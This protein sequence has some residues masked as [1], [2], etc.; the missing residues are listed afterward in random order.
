MNLYFIPLTTLFSLAIMLVYTKLAGYRQI[1]QLT[2]YDYINT[3]TLGNLAAQ[4]ATSPDEDF[5][6]ALIAIVLYGAFAILSS[7]LAR[8][9]RTFRSF[10]SGQPIVLMEKGRLYRDSFTK[11]RINLDDFEA[12][13]RAQGYFDL[14]QVG[15]AV[16]E[17]NGQM[18]V[19][20][21]SCARPVTTGDMSLQVDKEELLADVIMDGKVMTKNLGLT[22][23]DQ[24]YLQG[25]LQAAGLKLEDV[26]LATCDQRGAMVFYPKTKAPQDSVL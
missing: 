23:R 12:S 11:A 4:I 24:A 25:R 5:F 8:K 20:P 6:P 22:G 9:S 18:S 21:K 17:H 3:L 16:M 2:Y 13:L 26:F 14:N 7:L 1:S 15:Y 19:L 10:I